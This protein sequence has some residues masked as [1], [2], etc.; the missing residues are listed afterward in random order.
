MES[1][2]QAL[3][4][5]KIATDDEE[6]QKA[7]ELASALCD[8][9][10]NRAEGWLW[11]A[12]LSEDPEEAL[13]FARWAAQLSP[14][15]VTQ[16]AVQWAE[17]RLRARVD[18]HQMS[19]MSAELDF[20]QAR[21]KPA[22]PKAR[23]AG[24]RV[25]QRVMGAVMGMVLLLL[26][27]Q[28]GFSLAYQRVPWEFWFVDLLMAGPTPTA[29]E[30]PASAYLIYPTLVPTVSSGSL[31]NASFQPEQPEAA[32]IP[33]LLPG[34]L[35]SP[36]VSSA[37]GEVSHLWTQALTPQPPINNLSE[38]DIAGGIPT[39]VPTA[40][41]RIPAPILA[42]P[43]PA[44][45]VPTSA[46]TG[47]LWPARS[48]PVIYAVKGGDTL[49]KIAASFGLQETSLIWANPELE[50]NPELLTIKQELVIPALD[51]VLHITREGE[52]VES[53]AAAY[54][55][56]PAIV[57][58]FPGNYLPDG[59]A[60]PPIPGQRLMVPGG[61]KPY[62]P[63]PPDVSPPTPKNGQASYF[64]W[65]A[66]GYLTQTFSA[67]HGAIDI[68]APM[69]TPIFAAQSGE[70][71][72]SGWDNRGYGYAIVIDH[73]N[74][75]FTRYAHLSG[76]YSDVGD[77][78]QRGDVIALMGSTGRSTGPHVH[79]EIITSGYRYNPLDYLPR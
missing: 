72:F 24:S 56:D 20:R 76:M 2:N 48:E 25:W 17:A 53:I 8:A 51:G 73:H 31:I 4:R 38:E 3:T 59:A 14:S 26:G 50:R 47:A 57:Y 71:V 63:P 39:L 64:G 23:S 1:L 37:V 35:V 40:A 33:T 61:Q 10:P 70:V 46:P 75:W 18:F 15:L 22:A 78:V 6:L 9:W 58:W 66:G 62:E 34:P 30:P 27:F 68:A 19:S 29:E 55:V 16:Q 77:W 12:W 5:I 79:F 13:H 69:N 65:P 43:V 28:V 7:R 44:Q 45:V 36:E 49:E 74:G 41:A 52:T 67:H 32:T 42:T 54:A 21:P 60:S 11:R